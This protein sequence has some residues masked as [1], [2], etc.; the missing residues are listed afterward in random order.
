MANNR[1]NRREQKGNGGIAKERI[2]QKVRLVREN[3]KAIVYPF[4][5]KVREALL[6][7]VRLIDNADIVI[8][9]EWGYGLT[10]E[11][12]A[13][14]NE[15]VEKLVDK[16]SDV[17]E[18]ASELGGE[19]VNFNFSKYKRMKQDEKLNLIRN[20]NVIVD[21]LV[22]NTAHSEDLFE[23]L[24]TIDNYDLPIKQNSTMKIVEEKWLKPLKEFENAVIEAK[25]KALELVKKAKGDRVHEIRFS[26]LKK[27]IRS[28][29]AEEKK[30]E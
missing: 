8:R 3:P 17:I 5:T 11:E 7:P 16:A 13:K 6:R 10:G 22:S 24:M 23:A 18:R 20:S 2:E 15:T 29:L 12:V 19:Y 28:M 25:N 30:S 4:K 9:E 26:S 14:W 27:E 1:A 21:V